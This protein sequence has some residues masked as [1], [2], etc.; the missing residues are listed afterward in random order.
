M[1]RALPT[2]LAET[3]R[4][5]GTVL[6]DG[7][8][9]DADTGRAGAWL[10]AD[11]HKVL[12]ADTLADVKPVLAQVDNALAGGHHVAGWLAYEAGYAFES[13]RFSGADYHAPLAWFGV[14]DAPTEVAP[15]DLDRALGTRGKVANLTAG[16]REATYA[17]RIGR[18]RQ[19]IRDGDVYQINLTW[20]LAFEAEGDPL[21]LYGALRAA[22]PTAYGALVRSGDLDVL[23]LSPELFFRIQASGGGRTITARPMKGTAARG[24]TPEADDALAAGLTADEKNRAEN[25]MIVDLLRNDLGRVAAPG[26]VRVPRLF[27][28]ERYPTVT[29]MTSTVQADL[30]PEAALSDVFRALFPCGSVT[31]APKLRAME[32]IRDLEDTPRGVYCGA[33]GYA[34]PASGGGLGWAAFN[35][36][37]RTATF[38]GARGEYRVGSGVVWDSDAA[39]EWAECW[40][41]ARPLTDL[42]SGANAP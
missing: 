32:I 13:E 3:L 28:A 36:P 7:P 18:V 40:L 19:H 20:P 38:R 37:I 21:G 12:R 22:Q 35:V 10:F 29:Q 4:R 6:L 30:A 26:S 8:L 23:S 34:A 24:A 42:A 39:S 2:P 41:K 31:G 15:D 33:I 25:L 1:T 9:A 27:H 11:P 5:T 16:L 14:Y 17:E